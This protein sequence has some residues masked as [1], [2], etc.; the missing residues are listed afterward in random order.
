MAHIRG[1]TVVV[2]ILISLLAISG[3]A[4]RGAP[5]FTLFG[6]FFP[7]WMLVAG[8]GILLA[9]LARAVMIK[10]GLA[11]IVPMQLLVSVSAGLTIAIIVWALW[12]GP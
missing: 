11:Q 12:F 8:I 5:S 3:C 9:I 4:S 7:A 2:P 10:T 1:P 6:A